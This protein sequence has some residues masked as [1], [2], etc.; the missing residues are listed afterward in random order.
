VSYPGGGAIP[1]NGDVSVQGKRPDI[2]LAIFC[3]S[4]V[5]GKPGVTVQ[6]K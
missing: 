5:P 1:G 4:G 3:R 6:G 2:W